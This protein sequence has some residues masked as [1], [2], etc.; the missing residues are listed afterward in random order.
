M[1]RKRKW[2]KLMKTMKTK[3]KKFLTTKTTKKMEH[4]LTLISMKHLFISSTD[5]T[6]I[7][8][9]ISLIVLS[10]FIFILC[11]IC[12]Y[13]NYKLK[14]KQNAAK[15]KDQLV[16]DDI[17]VAI[18]NVPERRNSPNQVTKGKV[19]NIKE[20]VPIVSALD[21][22]KQRNCSEETRLKRTTSLDRSNFIKR[23]T[24]GENESNTTRKKIIQPPPLLSKSKSAN[25]QNNNDNDIDD[26]DDYM[27]SHF[28]EEKFNHRDDNDS[29]NNGDKNNSDENS[30]VIDSIEDTDIFDEEDDMNRFNRPGRMYEEDSFVED[31]DHIGVYDKTNLRLQ[32]A[33]PST[34]GLTLLSLCENFLDRNENTGEEEEEGKGEEAAVVRRSLGTDKFLQFAQEM[35]HDDSKMNEEKEKMDE[36]DENDENEE[37]EVSDNEDYEEDGAS[38]NSDFNETSFHIQY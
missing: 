2:M 17:K 1:K 32:E 23:T 29:D 18:N 14:Q 37:E 24:S 28:E 20:S 31:P 8:L 33:R 21:I 26:D 36:I 6:T 5:K 9:L 3:K 10:V 13:N 38:I 11:I 4:Q 16:S 27:K 19:K 35:S 15:T 30:E 34:D 12:F 25:N 7:P 22:L